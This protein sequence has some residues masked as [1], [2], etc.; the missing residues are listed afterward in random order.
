[1]PGVSSYHHGTSSM[2]APLCNACYCCRLVT[3]PTPSLQY[4]IRH[5]MPRY[6][7]P[8]T[9]LSKKKTIPGTTINSFVS[10]DIYTWYIYGESIEKQD[11][12]QTE[13]KI[14]E[15]IEGVPTCRRPFSISIVVYSLFSSS[16]YPLHITTKEPRVHE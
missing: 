1:M 15:A 8:G 11:I 4:D 9:I 13:A 12:T 2:G 3:R 14:F 5:D 7:I 10:P 6:T 16:V